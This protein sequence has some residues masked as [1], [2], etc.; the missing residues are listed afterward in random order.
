LAR[1]QRHDLA[2]DETGA[3]RRCLV[4]G[5]VQPKAGLVRFVVSPEGAI[6][7]DVAERLPGRGLWLTSRRDIVSAAVAKRLFGRAAR[8]PVI[9]DDALADRVE[10]LLVARCRDLIGLARRAGEA[11]M[12]FVK[13]ERMLAAGVAGLLL[14]AA[15]GARDGRVKLQALAPGLPERAELTAVELGAAFGREAVVHVAL[16]EG[17]LAAALTRELDR[18]N[19]FR[20]TKLDVVERA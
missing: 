19:G 10:A 5:A 20:V 2:E 13:V 14:G 3:T 6:L 1:A 7:P 16:R 15:D 9:V 18:L 11:T 8:R 17:R 4:T 12:G